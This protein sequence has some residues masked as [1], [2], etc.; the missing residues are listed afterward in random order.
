MTLLAILK[1]FG[2][3]LSHVLPW[4]E[5]GLKVGTAI[6]GIIDPPLAPIFIS[7]EVILE[8]LSGQLA[9]TKVSVDDLQTLVKA[10][11]TVHAASAV[12]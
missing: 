2:K 12:K 3:D 5:E 10:V 11:A 8:K 6:T 7:I 9:P 4:I 1:T